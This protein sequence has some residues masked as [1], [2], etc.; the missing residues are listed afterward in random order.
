MY[1]GC[2][3]FPLVVSVLSAKLALLALQCPLSV[4]NRPDISSR[5]ISE[6]SA[7]EELL[8]EL[9]NNKRKFPKFIITGG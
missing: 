4:V 5:R 2:W 1:D 7:G 6:Q 8:S 3:E 9:Y